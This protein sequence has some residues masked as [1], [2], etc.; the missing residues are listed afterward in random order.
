MY[1]T[2]VRLCS[3]ILSVA[4]LLSTLTF[5]PTNAAEVKES[6]VESVSNSYSTFYTVK[7]E[8]GTH[9]YGPTGN[10][11][12]NKE[13]LP[14]DVTVIETVK[15]YNK[16]KNNNLAETSGNKLPKSVDNSTSVYFPEIG[17]Q[18]GL[19]SCLF[20]AQIYYQYT[21]E[22]NKMSGIPTTA[23]NVFSPQWSYN[24][25]TAGDDMQCT[26]PISLNFMKYQGSVP[27][28]QVP[29][30]EQYQNAYPTEEIWRN[31]I[32]YR[33]KEF[34]FFEDLGTHLNQ[35]TSPDDSDLVPVKTALNNGEIL[36][37][38]TMMY[39][40]TH[41]E[42]TANEKAPENNKYIGECAV[43]SMDSY[44]GGH[45]M[46]LVGYNDDIWIDINKNSKIDKGELGAFKVA[47]SWGK[48]YGN[49][50][51]CWVAYD[52]LN[53][54]S[55]VY[56]VEENKERDC[57]FTEITRIEVQPYG[58][59]SELYLKYTLNTSDR[60]Q[61]STSITAE[62][63]ATVHTSL[64]LSN[65]CYGDPLAYDGSSSA[66]DATLIFPI[67]A[68]FPGVTPDNFRDYTWTVTFRDTSDRNHV[69]TVKDAEIINE[70][71]GEC[72][73]VNDTYPFTLDGNAKSIKYHESDLNHA[74]IYYRGYYTPSISYKLNGDEYE[75]QNDIAIEKNFEKYGYTHKFVIDLKT[76]DG[77]TLY[78]SN[79][80]KKV[81]DNNGMMFKA[82]KGVN[83]YI[84][85]NE[86]KPL[87]LEMTNDLNGVADVGRFGLLTTTA[88]GGYEPYLY[89][90]IVTNTTTG[91]VS[92][93]EFDDRPTKGHYFTEAG[94]YV[95][96]VTLKD[97]TG[98]KISAINYVTITPI[99]FEF[100]TF[101][102]KSQNNNLVNLHPITF[103][104]VTNY[105]NIGIHYQ[106]YN[107]YDLTIMRNGYTC[108]QVTIPMKYE[109]TNSEYMTSTV[110]AN[111]MPTESGTYTAKISATDC[112]GEYAEKTLTFV[113]NDCIIGDA[114]G[115]GEIN[116]VDATFLQQHLAKMNDYDEMRILTSD[117]DKDNDITINDVTLIQRYLAK[118]SEFGYVGEIL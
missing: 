105:E 95:I 5:M 26:T 36:S 92:V 31:A 86:A 104:A 76:S 88:S 43:T 69:L 48:E 23:D 41:T 27:M 94:D 28:N 29:Y 93:E 68:T 84:T 96:V 110:I 90:Y 40:W 102:A 91:A 9:Y 49:D 34:Y 3:T 116:I 7:D 13:V 59:D 82:E 55:C 70:A 78:F 61:V 2:K 73:K 21:Y 62:K 89:E 45:R 65:M 103:T 74:V 30:D 75:W 54:T 106:I 100:T 85:E 24:V 63:D 35:I 117:T 17:D 56:G 71:T 99:P 37:Y 80:D 107:E 46:T 77:A 112:E 57:I 4:L 79:E 44:E 22:Y 66:T 14:E 97:C 52:A 118:Y 18:G 111:W 87:S 20:W 64:A 109:L 42:L 10:N 114:D 60:T 39:G 67:Q 98:N 19:G 16:S 1:H 58:T 50:G 81:D 25:A 115:D 15:D 12:S 83:C 33:I 47:N 53:L 51:F 38:S 101:E 72:F 32:N 113:V 6:A 108:Y 8:Y 11:L